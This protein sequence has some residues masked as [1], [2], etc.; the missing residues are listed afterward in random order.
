[1]DYC[2]LPWGNV[3]SC[4]KKNKLL[5]HGRTAET[6]GTKKRRK[7]KLIL[8]SQQLLV[9]V[10]TEQPI[11]IIIQASMFKCCIRVNQGADAGNCYQGLPLKESQYWWFVWHWWFLDATLWFAIQ[12]PTTVAA[13]DKAESY[14]PQLRTYKPRNS[15]G[16]PWFILSTQDLCKNRHI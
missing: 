2:P 6:T 5:N 15:S 12:A 16:L 8:Q 9:A 14:Y 7:W 4:K 1:M 11:S 13:F 3:K 10:V